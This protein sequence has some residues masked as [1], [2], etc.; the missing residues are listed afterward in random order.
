MAQAEALFPDGKAHERAIGQWSRTVGR[1]FLNWMA[2]PPGRRWLD[3]ECG[4]KSFVEE[5]IVRCAPGELQRLAPSQAISL[6]DGAFDAA[7]LAQA[8]TVSPDPLVA[9]KQMARVTRPGGWVGAYM[10]DITGGGE[11]TYPISAGA[12]D[13][14]IMFPK[15]GAADFSRIHVLC[16]LWR[17][18]GLV[19]IDARTIRVLVSYE[20][21]DD[22]WEASMQG[23]RLGEAIQ[24]LT[25]EKRTQLHEH[26]RMTLPMDRDGGLSFYAWVNAV[27]GR[28]AAL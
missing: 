20:S 8:I 16:D 26:L 3:L 19:Q 4:D 21:F 12:K 11:P 15:T 9:V 22:Y 17:E 18:V 13:L 24:S 1:Q 2:I 14:G 5:L 23:G 6:E 10:W 28:V 7:V 27:K 25:P